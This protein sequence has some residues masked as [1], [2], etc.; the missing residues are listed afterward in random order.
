MEL[1]SSGGPAMNLPDFL[2]EVP[3][4]EIRLTGSRIGLYHVIS[5]FNHG[6]SLEQLQEEFPDLSPELLNKVLEFY[7]QNRAEVDAY[8]ARLEEESERQRRTWKPI[9][10]EELKRRWR[11]MGRTELP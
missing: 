8:M 7:H 4:G 5:D 1:Q 2:T 6:Y 11:A 10:V 3:Y 9:D